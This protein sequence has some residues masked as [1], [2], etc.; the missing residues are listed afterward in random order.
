MGEDVEKSSR[1]PAPSASTIND[2]IATADRAIRNEFPDAPCQVAHGFHQPFLHRRPMGLGR[3]RF[4]I[5]RLRVREPRLNI[6]PLSVEEVARFWSSFHTARDLAIGVL[7]YGKR[8]SIPEILRW[9]QIQLAVDTLPPG[10]S[11]DA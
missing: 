10:V 11:I 4:E 3:P 6:V 5:S 1:Q 7:M 9:P 2:R 8:P